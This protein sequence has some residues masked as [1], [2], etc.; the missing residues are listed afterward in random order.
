M[1]EKISG[2][3]NYKY[4]GIIIILLIAVAVLGMQNTGIFTGQATGKQD[5][6]VK[7][8]ENIYSLITENPV[9]VLKVEEQSGLYRIVMR[10]TLPNGQQNVAEA[11]VTKDGS[12]ILTN[13][14]NTTAYADQLTKEKAFAE[15]V[16]SKR[17]V[18]AGQATD[19]NTIQQLRLLGN[20]AYK[21]YVDCSGAN[22]QVCQ[23]ANITQI[24][25]VVY[26]NASYPG[27]QARSFF[28]D[29]TGCRY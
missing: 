23:Q 25:L 14:L 11:F 7:A 19:S 27:V 24:P 22:L 15:C 10:T 13:P 26:N 5:A 9:E 21:F 1:P 12:M 29:L 28:E 2:R 17:L 18:V 20:F 16:A 3:R 6:A 4:I 8:V